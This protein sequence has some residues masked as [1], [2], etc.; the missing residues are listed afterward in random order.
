MKGRL[1]KGRQKKEDIDTI[2]NPYQKA[3][4]NVNFKDENRIEQMINWSIFSNKIRYV[5]PCKNETSKLTIRLLEE[6]KHKKLFST[7]EI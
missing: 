3:I 7:L 1:E 4:T 6:K 5:N 2:E